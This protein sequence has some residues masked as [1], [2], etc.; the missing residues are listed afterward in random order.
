[1]STERNVLGEPLQPCSDDP[2]TGFFRDGHC[3]QGQDGSSRHLVCVE[4][5]AEFLAFTA[6][7]HVLVVMADVTHYAEALREIST[8]REEIPGVDLEIQ[9]I[10]ASSQSV[11]ITRI[12]DTPAAA[13]ELHRLAEKLVP[14][15]LGR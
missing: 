6:G 9:L 3:H 5:T 7:L 4:V 1:M 15:L 2:L 11:E 12:S 14:P 10:D 13:G 8:A